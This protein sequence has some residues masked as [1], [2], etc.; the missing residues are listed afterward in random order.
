MKICPVF[1]WL[2]L[3]DLFN[4]V[5]FHSWLLDYQR[6]PEG[7][8]PKTAVQAATLE[9]TNFW[10]RWGFW[11]CFLEWGQPNLFLDWDTPL[12]LVFNHAMLPRQNH[13]TVSSSLRPVIHHLQGGASYINW[14][15]NPMKT[16]SI[17]HRQ[18]PSWN[19][20]YMF[21]NWTLS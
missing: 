19:W 14:F 13:P 7:N 18:K 21:T 10:W 20:S 8:Q 17:Y 5:V 12:I 9:I 11:W 16:S 3:I 4:V 1:R 2:I 6:D 15:I